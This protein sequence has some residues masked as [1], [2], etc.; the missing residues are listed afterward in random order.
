MAGPIEDIQKLRLQLVDLA[1]A[2][3]SCPP[4]DLAELSIHALRAQALVDLAD[5]DLRSGPGQRS[6]PDRY[7]IALTMNIDAEG[8]VAP[9]G[10]LPAGSLG[11]TTFY[12]LVLGPESQPLDIGR[13]QRSWPAPLAA[14]ITRRDQ[15]CRFPDVTH[16]P[17]IAISTTANPGNTAGIPPSA[18]GYCCAAG[19]TRSST[20]NTGPSNSTNTNTPNS[21]N[22][23]GATRWTN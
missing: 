20:A 18:T 9:V 14:A 19:T 8:N 6:R 11:D 2:V 7:H 15:R 22:P 23:T 16:P 3:E 12:R 5:Q 4:E 17:A 21:A 1:V 13:A 10:P